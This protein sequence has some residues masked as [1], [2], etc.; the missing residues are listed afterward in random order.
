MSSPIQE[1]NLVYLCLVQEF[2]VALLKKKLTMQA[3]ILKS[4]LY[5]SDINYKDVP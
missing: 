4:P 1:T 3:C 2:L 5:N